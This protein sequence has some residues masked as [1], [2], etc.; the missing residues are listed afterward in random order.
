VANLVSA[1]DVSSH[2]PRD[3]TGLIDQYKPDQ[4][5]VKL[6]LPIETIPQSYTRDQI[7]SARNAGC[8]IGG[9]VWCYRSAD[10]NQTVQD[11]V[12]LANAC[13]V[14]LPI[15][16]FDCETETDRNG[17]VLDPGPDEAWLRTAVAKCR[18]LGVQPGIYTGDWW[19]KG[20]MGNPD[21]NPFADLPLW[22]AEPNGVANP[23]NVSLYGGWTYAY[24]KQWK[25][26]G[27]PDRDTFLAEVSVHPVNLGTPRLAQLVAANPNI[28]D[29]LVTWQAQRH[30][31][32]EDPLD[33]P[34]FRQFQTAIGAPDPGSVEFIGFRRATLEQLAARNPNI[35][36][37]L[38]TWQTQRRANGEDP[39]DYVAFR[40]FQIAIFAPDPGTGE[41]IGFR[42]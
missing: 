23:A 32:G 39:F 14:N 12:D 35:G 28:L 16:W 4:V 6:Y 25:S 21:P 17:D 29:Q 18:A 24:G 19:W 41:F 34:A 3:L 9:Y 36:P 31:N 40:Q 13:D 22:T 15:L 1:I 7:T 10:P 11:A 5:I 26:T 27:G 2:N 20:Y 37:Q 8:T 30:Q 38:S 42:G 33:Y